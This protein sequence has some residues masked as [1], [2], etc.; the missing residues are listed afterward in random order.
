MCSSYF[1]LDCKSV[2]LKN[3][4]GP[5]R[6][7]FPSFLYGKAD[8]NIKNKSVFGGESCNIATDKGADFLSSLNYLT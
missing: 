5:K 6:L 7:V 2:Y 8:A 1:F 3:Y 4:I